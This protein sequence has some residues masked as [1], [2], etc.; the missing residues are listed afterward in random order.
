MFSSLERLKKERDAS[1]IC[2]IS[3]SFIGIAI[4]AI[5]ISSVNASAGYDATRYFP[6]KVSS[7]EAS[8]EM[9]ARLLGDVDAIQ[10][11]LFK[12][13]RALNKVRSRQNGK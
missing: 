13:T 5:M 6:Q 10:Y 11:D 1:A 7:E 3:S 12:L 9:M 4:F 2:I 8:P